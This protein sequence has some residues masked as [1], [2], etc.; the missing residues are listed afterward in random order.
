[1][2]AISNMRMYATFKGVHVWKLLGQLDDDRL[3]GKMYSY[4]L[5]HTN[6]HSNVILANVG[7]LNLIGIQFLYDR[8]NLEKNN[9]TSV[10]YYWLVGFFWL[11]YWSITNHH[12]SKRVLTPSETI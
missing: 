10:N 12:I 2:I 8:P 5:L 1:M 7:H 6:Y 4:V 3:V 11:A 9:K